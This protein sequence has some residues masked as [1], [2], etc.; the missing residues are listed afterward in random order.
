[1]T[2]YNKDMLPLASKLNSD[3]LCLI[4][5]YREEEYREKHKPM[6]EKV[7]QELVELE[8]AKYTRADCGTYN[9][10]FSMGVGIKTKNISHMADQEKQLLLRCV[11]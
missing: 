9:P 6:M 1:M 3:V 8:I 5:S 10:G 4:D 2:H 7:L 11:N